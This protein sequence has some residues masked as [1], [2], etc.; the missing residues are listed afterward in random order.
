MLIISILLQAG[1]SMDAHLLL[2][3][4]HYACGKYADGINSFQQA[5]L[6]NLSEKKLPL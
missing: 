3:K 5:D 2:G 4:L 1:V 6:H